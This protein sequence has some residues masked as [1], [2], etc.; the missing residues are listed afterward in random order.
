MWF[1]VVERWHDFLNVLWPVFF[2]SGLLVAC[3]K[4]WLWL[5]G[6]AH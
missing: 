6:V 5:F 2:M 3:F 4:F 1:N